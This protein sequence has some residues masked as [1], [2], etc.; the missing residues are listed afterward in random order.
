M[1][2]LH[3]VGCIA[4]DEELGQLVTQM[5]LANDEEYPGFGDEVG[6][7]LFAWE[8]LQEVHA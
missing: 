7:S 6:H 2:H 1:V 5:L 4:G 8:H 3:S